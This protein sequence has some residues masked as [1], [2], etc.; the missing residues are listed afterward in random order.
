[1]RKLPRCLLFLSTLLISV[2]AF[3][4]A[5]SW[6]AVPAILSRIVPPRFPARE[7]VITTFGAH[8]GEDASAAIAKAIDAC[9][10]AGGG[11][12]IVP[13]GDYVTGPIRLRSHVDLH[14]DAGA[15]LRFSQDTSRYPLTLTRW[16]G[17]E[18]MNFSPLIYASDCED[19]AITGEGTLDGQADETHSWNWKA[20]N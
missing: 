18:L 8:D 11:H 5:D 10:R 14:I 16:E 2:P 1:M 20:E 13:K 9:A 7:F 6:T 15:T 12:V 17:V 3:A 4:D 19:I